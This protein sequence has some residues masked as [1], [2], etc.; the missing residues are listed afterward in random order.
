MKKNLRCISLFVFHT[1]LTSHVAILTKTEKFVLAKRAHG[2]DT[3]R[4]EIPYR[5]LT[6]RAFEPL[7]CLGS[8][9]IF[10]GHHFLI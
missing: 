10:D 4:S 7:N 9:F 6:A 2:S 1:T 8:I 5:F 3:A